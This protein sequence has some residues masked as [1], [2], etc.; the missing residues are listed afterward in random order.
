M[1]LID[2]NPFRVL[3]LPITASRKEIEKSIDRLKMYAGMGK[4][5]TFDTDYPFLPLIDRNEEIV[6][7]AS[8]KIEQNENRLFYSLFWFWNNSSVDELSIEVLKKGD[9]DKAIE[10]WQKSINKGISN[11]NVSSFKNLSILYLYLSKSNGSLNADYLDKAIQ[12]SSFYLEESF[13]AQFSE[14]ITGRNFVQKLQNYQIKLADHVLE[15]V[16]DNKSGEIFQS[17]GHFP[18]YVY[19]HI[20]NQF[21]NEPTNK[22]EEELKLCQN[23]RSET[24]WKS[25]SYAIELW[26]NVKEYILYLK[27]LMTKDNPQYVILAD[28]VSDEILQCSIDYH[29]EWLHDEE[30]EYIPEDET[31]PIVK[32]ALKVA[33]S[34]SQVSKVKENLSIINNVSVQLKQKSNVENN[35]KV[36]TSI[37][38]KVEEK[39][40]LSIEQ[41][42]I[43]PSHIIKSTKQ[44]LTELQNICGVNSEI[45]HQLAHAIYGYAMTLMIQYTN[46]SQDYEYALSFLYRI[47]EINKYDD[48]NERLLAN[49]HI[50]QDNIEISK[51]KSGCYIATM[52]YKDVNAPEVVALRTFRDYTLKNY[53]IGKLFIAL[54]YRFSP[55]F[56]KIFKDS[57]MVNRI[58]KAILDPFVRFISCK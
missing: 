28:K 51:N 23:K 19:N 2:E 12:Y 17:F 27:S 47:Y 10:L 56:V 50:L 20:S 8:R 38:N 46:K 25:D 5:I 48:I 6:E 41:C 54:Y 13:F 36:I 14:R 24:P 1:K 9:T 18:N 53:Y 35:I 22:I 16:G 4:K 32:L 39:E 40:P 11:K 37:L 30:E 3:G 33:S 26:N 43:E 15:E 52:V 34:E 45:C 29:N 57:I 58:G 42:K 49:M 7:E 55:I 31:I 21:I 44:P